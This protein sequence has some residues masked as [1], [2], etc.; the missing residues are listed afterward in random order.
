[1]GSA[2]EVE[3]FAMV[4]IAPS[5]HAHP[6]AVCSSAASSAS[7]GAYASVAASFVD[8]EPSLIFP[9]SRHTHLFRQPLHVRSSLPFSFFDDPPL[10]M[11]PMVFFQASSGAYWEPSE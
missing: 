7:A 5:P 2:I 4:D 6:D 1:M 3:H 10:W 11:H 8:S 9:G